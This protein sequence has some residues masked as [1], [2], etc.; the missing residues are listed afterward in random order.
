MRTGRLFKPKSPATRRGFRLHVVASAILA[1]L[2]TALLTAA[3][4]ATLPGAGLLLLLSRLLPAALLLLARFLVGILIGILVLAHRPSFR[5]WLEDL[6]REPRPSRT[7]PRARHSFPKGAAA[8]L[9]P[10]GVRLPVFPFNEFIDQRMKRAGR[11]LFFW[12]LA[13]PLPILAPIWIFGGLI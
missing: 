10:I 1:L 3:L 2:A 13:V 8:G 9:D 5:R 4:L 12:L 11:H 6:L 7:T